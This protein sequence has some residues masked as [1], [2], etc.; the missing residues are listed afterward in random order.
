MSEINTKHFAGKAEEEVPLIHIP[1]R[2]VEGYKTEL[3]DIEIVALRPVHE[4]QLSGDVVVYLL[5]EVGSDGYFA[6]GVIRRSEVEENTF[7]FNNGA[8]LTG[9]SHTRLYNFVESV[10]NGTVYDVLMPVGLRPN[11]NWLINLFTKKKLSIDC[12]SPSTGKVLGVINVEYKTNREDAM[13]DTDMDSLFRDAKESLFSKKYVV[14]DREL[15]SQ[16]QEIISIVRETF[17]VGEDI[18]VMTTSLE[19]KTQVIRVNLGTDNFLPIYIDARWLG[20][21]KFQW[22]KL[23]LTLHRVGVKDAGVMVKLLEKDWQ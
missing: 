10:G 15:K 14:G 21:D 8:G 3:L 12:L 4:S 11:K 19:D 7:V 5:R 9:A 18:S 2:F 6:T 16:L 17:A 1:D 13:L 23:A 22:G 20:S